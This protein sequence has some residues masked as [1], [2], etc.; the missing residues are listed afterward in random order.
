MEKIFCLSDLHK[1]SD[2]Y[3]QL[4]ATT[5]PKVLLTFDLGKVLPSWIFKENYLKNF[6]FLP[7]IWVFRD[8]NI[9][10]KLL[11]KIFE[12]VDFEQR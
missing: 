6:E 10:G 2:L 1:I 9:I 4:T 11:G 7:G 12:V 3:W 8:S 5:S